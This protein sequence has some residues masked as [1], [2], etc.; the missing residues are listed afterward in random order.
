[1]I[2]TTEVPRPLGSCHCLPGS[3][4]RDAIHDCG[5]ILFPPNR[6]PTETKC[7]QIQEPQGGGFNS[8]P[9]AWFPLF[10][11]LSI[12]LGNSG[13]ILCNPPRRSNSLKNIGLRRATRLRALD[14]QGMSEEVKGAK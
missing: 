7:K 3:L 14:K 6:L 1:M 9:D 12:R 2:E 10:L 5:P 13:V 4:R 8:S 11:W